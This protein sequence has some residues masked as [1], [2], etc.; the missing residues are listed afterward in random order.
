MGA[1]YNHGTAKDEGRVPR[2]AGYRLMEFAQVSREALQEVAE[3]L[4]PR[5]EEI[6]NAWV[7]TQ[8]SAWPPPAFS[9]SELKQI[10]GGVVRNMLSRMKARE[11][12]KCIEYFELVGTSLAAR[13]FPYE[14][15]I[16]SLHFL[17]ES[18]MPF[19]IE[20]QS[21]KTLGWLVGL[22]EFLHVAIATMATSYFQ[23]YRKELLNEAEVGRIVQEGLL[24]DVPK[25]VIGLEVAYIYIAPGEQTKIGGDFVDLFTLD[26]GETAFIVGDLSGHGIEAA[27]DAAMLRFQ[28]KSLIWENLD[29]VDTMAKLNRM[30]ESELQGNQFATALA[31]I[32]NGKGHLKLV[33]AGHPT[34]LICDSD[35][36]ML[37]PGGVALAI[38]R[39]S[40]YLLNEVKL[41]TD[42]VFVAYTDGL[43]EARRNGEFYGEERLIDSVS[44]M[45]KATA[46][47]IADYL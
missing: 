21:E 47:D 43:I 17:E 29:L 37:E 24:P 10:F 34:P 16:I 46:R 11:P 32:Y 6:I 9:K 2:F 42:A 20:S 3:L 19:L 15:L 14:A 45:R 25:Y 33:N 44:K 8:F 22:D 35:C 1:S 41:E 23:E 7:G 5:E 36:Y 31:G 13:N 39:K 27:V 38:D 12:E 4:L 28:F 26:S 18:Y 40:T 30:L